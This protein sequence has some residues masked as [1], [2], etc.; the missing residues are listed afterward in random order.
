LDLYPD[1]F[2]PQSVNPLQDGTDTVVHVISTN[3]ALDEDVAT[4]RFKYVP[5]VSD[6]ENINLYWVVYP[7]PNTEI[8]NYTNSNS[9]LDITIK[10]F[11]KQEK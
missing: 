2:D 9:F 8:N 6:A 11:V 7:H 4:T 1:G 5:D 10:D 3:G